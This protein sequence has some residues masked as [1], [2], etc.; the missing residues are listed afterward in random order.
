MHPFL[1]GLSVLYSLIHPS[2]SIKTLHHVPEA[3]CHSD[4]PSGNNQSW[5]K[6]PVQRKEIENNPSTTSS[7]IHSC[8]LLFCTMVV[9]IDIIKP[10]SFCSSPVS[11]SHSSITPSPPSFYGRN[12]LKCQSFILPSPYWSLKTI[13]CSPPPSQL[14]ADLWEGN[15][16][17]YNGAVL[18]DRE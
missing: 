8:L 14:T 15:F 9:F 2:I 12:A 5:S 18:I 13:G 17:G 6:H 3:S 1:F 11:F 4:C 7:Y 16:E 10:S